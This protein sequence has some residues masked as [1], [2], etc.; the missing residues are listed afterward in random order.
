VLSEEFRSSYLLHSIYRVQ[1]S[2]FKFLVCAL[3]SGS[4]CALFESEME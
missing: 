1:F 2:G 3:R 4:L